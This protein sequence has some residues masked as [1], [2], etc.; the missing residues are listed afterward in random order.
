[1]LLN[2]GRH[3]ETNETIVPADVVAHVARGLTVSAGT[4]TYPDVVSR[5]L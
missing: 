4:A 3:P 5:A 2:E 1:M